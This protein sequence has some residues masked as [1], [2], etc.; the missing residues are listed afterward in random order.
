MTTEQEYNEAK[1]KAMEII[2]ARGQA[3]MHEY[4]ESANKIESMIVIG[5]HVREFHIYNRLGKL[6]YEKQVDSRESIRQSA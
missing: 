5:E 3:Y 1:Q 4:K 2:K 6:S